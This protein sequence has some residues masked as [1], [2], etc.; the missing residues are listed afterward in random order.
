LNKEKVLKQR[1]LKELNSDC[2]NNEMQSNSTGEEWWSRR[3][4]LL[5]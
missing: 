1:K 2:A 4:V 5:V 3:E